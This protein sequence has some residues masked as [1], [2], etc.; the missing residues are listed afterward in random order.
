MSNR[1]GECSHLLDVDT[2]I[3][4]YKSCGGFEFVFFVKGIVAPGH[5]N[6]AVKFRKAFCFVFFVVKKENF[7]IDPY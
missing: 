1:Q 3:L 2:S 7:P 4:F 5:I 6:S